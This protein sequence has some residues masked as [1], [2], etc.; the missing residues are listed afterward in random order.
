MDCAVEQSGGVDMMKLEETIHFICSTCEP[1]DR[2]GSVKLNKVLFYSD[3]TNYAETG[4]SITGATYVKRQR[5]PVPKQ[6]VEAIDNLKKAGRLETRH[7]SVFEHVRREFDTSGNTDMKVFVPGEVERIAAMIQFVC[8]H[9][10]DGISEVSHTVVWEVADMGEELPYDSFFVS[11]LDD[12]TDVALSHA[13]KAV[14]RA[15][16]SGL[17]YA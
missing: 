9:S 15:E 5:G 2:L 14:Q 6:V 16:S 1:K 7:V 12:V 13:V 10:A 17:V 8:G 3:M 4:K 11:Y